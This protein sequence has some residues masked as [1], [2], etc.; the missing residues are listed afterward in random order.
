VRKSGLPDLTVERI[1]LS[2]D[3]VEIQIVNRGSGPASAPFWVDLYIDP[4]TVPTRVNQTW[5]VVGTQGLVW[6]ITAE[7]LPLEPGARLTLRPGD[8]FYSPGHS[9]QLA[10]LTASTRLYAQVDSYNQSTSFGA[11]LERDEIDGGP[12]NNIAGGAAAQT[13]GRAPQ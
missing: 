11:V 12:Y 9:R 3:T 6:G 8:R 7:A 5:S 4:A 2:G 1:A 13:S 10:P